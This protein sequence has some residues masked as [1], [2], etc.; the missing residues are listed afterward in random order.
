[1]YAS[2][3]FETG[4]LEENP[5]LTR[6][7]SIVLQFGEMLPAAKS[8]Y[9]IYLDNCFTS[10][11]LF[12]KLRDIVVFFTGI[13]P[14]LRG[15]P[16][17]KKPHFPPVVAAPTPP[18][19][20]NGS[21]KRRRT[22]TGYQDVALQ[23]VSGDCDSEVSLTLNHHTDNQPGRGKTLRFLLLQSVTRVGP[24]ALPAASLP[25][26]KEQARLRKAGK[27]AGK[28]EKEQLMKPG[29]GINAL[30]N[31]EAL[32][33]DP[34]TVEFEAFDTG[35]TRG[36]EVVLPDADPVSLLNIVGL[37]L[38]TNL[39]QHHW[40]NAYNL[41][42]LFW[43]EKMWDILAAN[44]NKYA[45]LKGAQAEKPIGSTKSRPWHE[46]NA[47]ELKVYIGA[48]IYMAVH[49]SPSTSDYWNTDLEMGPIHTISGQ[50]AQTRFEQLRRYLHVGDPADNLPKKRLVTA[51]HLTMQ[52]SPP[53]LTLTTWMIRILR[54]PMRMSHT[55]R[56]SQAVK[57]HTI[58]PA[59]TI[60]RPQFEILMA[61]GG[62]NWSLSP[63]LS[64]RIANLV[65]Y[66]AA[67]FL[68]MK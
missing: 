23:P 63:A 24:V 28:G 6:T 62:S 39:V 16:A 4:E 26:A 59:V 15:Q 67:M 17:G 8:P 50:I 21:R 3:E 9:A 52:L 33:P 13:M 2:R 54:R 55:T 25:A 49:H 32:N 65:G 36:P 20:E 57:S 66:L 41:F 19:P 5:D 29:K 64:A 68:S 53:S 34:S 48:V 35:A 12:Q 38:I 18:G 47:N 37:D 7:G 22:P 31:F 14:R 11:S 27:P 51:A 46:T 44:T 60:A 56:T 42:S 1:M 45:K 43:D 58:S 40:E 30:E 10:V 61:N